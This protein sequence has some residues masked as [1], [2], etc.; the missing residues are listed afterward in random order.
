MK[1]KILFLLLVFSVFLC[2]G[3]SKTKDRLT[4][5]RGEVVI[6]G[7]LTVHVSNE[8]YFEFFAKTWGVTDLTKQ[9]SYVIFDDSYEDSFNKDFLNEDEDSDDAEYDVCSAN[10]FFVSKRKVKRNELTATTPVLWCFCSD[11]EFQVFLPLYFKAAIPKSEQYI[12]VGNFDYYL[13][14]ASFSTTR[15]EVS[16]NFDEAKSF[17]ETKYGREINLCRVEINNLD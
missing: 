16:D 13:D 14:G 12:Y 10:E 3:E 5:G 7:K 15:I 6:V 9:D 2:F 17:L 1:K 4:P 11:D 8:K